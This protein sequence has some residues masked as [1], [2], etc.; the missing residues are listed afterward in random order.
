[1]L[2][3]GISTN[4][5]EKGENKGKA[6]LMILPPYL[7]IATYHLFAVIQPRMSYLSLRL[8]YLSL[9]SIS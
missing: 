3:I 7:C 4:I 9:I 1:M 6:V 2:F 5:L 8:L